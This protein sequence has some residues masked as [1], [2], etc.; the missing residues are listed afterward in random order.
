VSTGALEIG[1]RAMKFLGRAALVT[2]LVSLAMTLPASAIASPTWTSARQ[3]ALPKGATGIPDGFFSSLS[4]TGSSDCEAAGS[5][6]SGGGQ[7]LGLIANESSGRWTAPVSLQAPAGAAGNQGVT[8][9]GVSC[10]VAGNCAAVGSYE[11]A[12]GDIAAFVDNERGGHWLRAK[13]LP[14]PANALVRGQNALVRSVSCSSA[15]TCSAIGTYQDNNPVGTRTEGFVANERSG[16]WSRARQIDLP[17]SNFNPFVTVSQI[18]CSSS[19][20]CVGVGSFINNTDV[21]EALVVNEVDGVW[22]RAEALTLPV[23]ASRFADASVTEVTCLKD[24]SCAAFGTFDATSGDL[25]A[26]SASESGG[27]WTSASA[28]AM[29]A[30]AA[31]NPRVFLFGFGGIACAA[32]DNCSV[33]GQYKDSA[34]DY[35]GFLENEVDG[36]W[37]PA[38]QVTL[39]TNGSSGGP[40]GGVVAISCPSLGGCQASGSYLDTAGKYQA[41]VFSELDGVWQRGDE[42]TLPGG[43]GSVGVDGGIYAIYCASS[44]SCVGVGSFLKGASTYEGFTLAS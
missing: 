25:E 32:A 20:D 30:N 1:V 43:A 3:V 14:L 13:T 31:A 40:N 34:G 16:T 38:T 23:S 10:G 36:V 21:T 15:N 4:C 33:G 22:H 9:Y 26:M 44:T 2:T 17:A 35:Q 12:H 42:V 27:V 29:P 7:I 41:V 5:Y 6:S 18:A 11:N 39:P 19:V 37:S 28:L 24:S 8:V